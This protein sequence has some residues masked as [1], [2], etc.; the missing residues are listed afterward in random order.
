MLLGW[1]GGISHSSA[2][3]LAVVTPIVA[4]LDDFTV[5]VTHT[6]RR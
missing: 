5:T 3:V 1:A 4:V 2:L 6:L